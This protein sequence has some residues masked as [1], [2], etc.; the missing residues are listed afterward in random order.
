MKDD[1]IP[2]EK[3]PEYR[4]PKG[5]K[6][7]EDIIETDTPDGETFKIYEKIDEKKDLKQNIEIDLKNFNKPKNKVEFTENQIKLDYII[8]EKYKGKEINDK[9]D[10]MKEYEKYPAMKDLLGF[11]KKKKC[12]VYIDNSIDQELSH[13]LQKYYS[14][15]DIL[16]NKIRICLNIDKEK[17]KDLEVVKNIIDK[18][19]KKIS[20]I[21][22]IPETNLKVTNIRKNCLLFDI[23]YVFR[24]GIK[25]IIGLFNNIPQNLNELRQFL[26]NIEIEMGDNL[27]PEDNEE[28]L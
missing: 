15:E 3:E 6:I 23:Y 9:F 5:D 17:L 8:S 25:F 7:L 27:E 16:K 28:K 18:I 12:K 21:T 26:R 14:S 4:T 20:T 2:Q 10:K 11:Y 24:R 22:K 19:V 13:Q 1:I